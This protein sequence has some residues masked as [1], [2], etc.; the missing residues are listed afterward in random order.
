MGDRTDYISR[1]QTELYERNAKDFKHFVDVSDALA[2]LM[3]WGF[4]RLPSRFKGNDDGDPDSAV[5]TVFVRMFND[6]EV[7]NLCAL[8]GLP[9]QSW[10]PL[11]DAVECMM[12]MRLFVVRPEA[13]RRWITHA[14]EYTAGTTNAQLGEEGIAAIEYGLYGFLSDLAHPN[15]AGSLGTLTETDHGDGSISIEWGVGGYDHPRLIKLSL[16]FKLV[17]QLFAIVDPLTTVITPHLGEDV[18]N[19]LAMRSSA[20]LAVREATEHEAVE[21]EE[22]DP[23]GAAIAIARMESRLARAMRQLDQA[24]L[25]RFPDSPSDET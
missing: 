21:R 4:E 11:R 18:R 24:M 23:G 13:A 25:R 14:N 20:I 9:D 3:L 10:G 19:W 2:E 16:E 15:L 7:A 22:I 5:K 6:F 1:F 17:L 12:L 8:R